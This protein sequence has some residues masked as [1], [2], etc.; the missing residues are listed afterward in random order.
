VT[1]PTHLRSFIGG[2]WR[3]SSS[4]SWIADI[5]P[6]NADDVI[7]HVPAGTVDDTRAAV[8]S[9]STAFPAWR[10]LPGPTRAE[11]LYKWAA[12]IAARHEE[13]AQL[14]T[15]DSLFGVAEAAGAVGG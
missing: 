15:R 8:S 4:G 9:A 1:A 5:N 3:E 11:Y 14:V 2:E 7:G 12:A 6:S 13:L 10:A